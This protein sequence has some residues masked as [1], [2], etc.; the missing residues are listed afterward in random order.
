MLEFPKTL[1]RVGIAARV[2]HQGAS[3]LLD[4]MCYWDAHSI[5]CETQSHLLAGHPYRVNGNLS[6]VCAVEYAAQAFALHAS[7]KSSEP[8]AVL[9]LGYLAAVREL[10]LSVPSLHVCLGTLT[11]T[12][13]ELAAESR[14]LLYAFSVLHQ[15]TVI[16]QGRAAVVFA[17]IPR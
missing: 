4:R 1:D 10:L 7:L 2:P 15:D 17:D 6:A 13:K 3:C 5:V 14:K 8:D 9:R 12:A 16:A 11:I